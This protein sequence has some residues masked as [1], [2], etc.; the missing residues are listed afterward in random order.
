MLKQQQQKTCELAVYFNCTK[1]KIFEI[2]FVIIEKITSQGDAAHM[3]DC[4]SPEKLTGP[5][6]YAHLLLT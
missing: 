5:R 6:N 2:S 1:H 3:I 4:Y